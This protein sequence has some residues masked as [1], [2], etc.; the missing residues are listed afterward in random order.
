ALPR[1]ADAVIGDD[2]GIEFE[3]RLAIALAQLLDDAP[4]G[5]VAKGA[6]KTVESFVVGGHVPIC[7]KT[8][9]YVSRFLSPLLSDAGAADRPR[10]S[11]QPKE[12]GHADRYHPHHHR[13][14]ALAG[15]RQGAGARHARALGARGGGPALSGSARLVPRTERA[16]ASGAATLR[17]DPD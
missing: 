9:A 10:D 3:Q 17:A 4:P 2:A 6:E 14:R 5:D 16:R 13:L 7:N 11:R 8:V 1:L 15:R 12:S